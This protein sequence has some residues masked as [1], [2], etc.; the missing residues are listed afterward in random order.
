M[1]SFHL[2][3]SPTRAEWREGG[4]GESGLPREEKDGCVLS[5][6]TATS[7]GDFDCKNDRH[8]SSPFSHSSSVC[9]DGGREGE[10]RKRQT[11]D[12]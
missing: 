8:V 4:L 11:P 5:A 10:K 1:Q 2:S 7:G 6:M 9:R 3:N 12:N